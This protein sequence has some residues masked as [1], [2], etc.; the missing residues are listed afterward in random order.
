MS[1]FFNRVSHVGIV[2]KLKPIFE[3]FR[4]TFCLE[5]F[6]FFSLINYGQPSAVHKIASIAIDAQA[7]SKSRK[8]YTSQ[9]DLR[10]KFKMI[11]LRHS[12]GVVP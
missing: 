12:L 9:T 2:D 5:K 7:N 10:P 8:N 6:R 3:L 1:R 11:A 4:K